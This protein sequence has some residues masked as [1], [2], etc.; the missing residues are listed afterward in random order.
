[1]LP[2]ICPKAAP[3]PPVELR[4]AGDLLAESEVHY[5]SLGL[6]GDEQSIHWVGRQSSAETTCTCDLATA[7]DG[8]RPPEWHNL[9]QLRLILRSLM[10]TVQ[11]WAEKQ[12]PPA[13]L[14][15]MD[16]IGER[17]AGLIRALGWDLPRFPQLPADQ[18]ARLRGPASLPVI[19]LEGGVVLMAGARDIRV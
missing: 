15:Q 5:R 3:K 2:S 4:P 8:P 9:R 10:T 12:I 17:A 11:Q 14:E 18:A 7:C 13:Y 1:A 16:Q 19:L 6:I